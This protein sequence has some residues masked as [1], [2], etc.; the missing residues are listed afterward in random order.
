MGFSKEKGTGEK[1]EKPFSTS[2]STRVAFG[3][4]AMGM[5]LPVGY[6]ASKLGSECKITV[7]GE[8]TDRGL[9]QG[10]V[11]RVVKNEGL[12]GKDFIVWEPHSADGFGVSIEEGDTVKFLDGT[13]VGASGDCW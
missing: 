4:L 10:E 2:W 13:A 11:T 3:F 1:L 5:L 6:Y 12:D 9:V 8:D 7:N